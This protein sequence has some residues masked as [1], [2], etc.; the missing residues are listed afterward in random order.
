MESHIVR[1]YDSLFW[2]FLRWN[3][4]DLEKNVDYL[5]KHGVIKIEDR[6]FHDNSRSVVVYGDKEWLILDIYN[7]R[8][9]SYLDKI[10]E[11]LVWSIHFRMA[12]VCVLSTD[13][14]RHFM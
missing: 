6:G 7:P 11:P 2:R 10:I 3:I 12:M 8:G 5:V 4:A 1:G 13:M 9:G 14:V